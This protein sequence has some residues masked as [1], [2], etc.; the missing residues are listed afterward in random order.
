MSVEISPVMNTVCSKG[1]HGRDFNTPRVPFYYTDCV[2]KSHLC[3]K[4]FYPRLSS[5]P[6]TKR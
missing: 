6:W 2:V 5:Y 1:E 4:E 3:S